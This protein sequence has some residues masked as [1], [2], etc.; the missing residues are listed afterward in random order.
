[1][2]NS[3]TN[4]RQPATSHTWKHRLIQ[5]GI[6]HL[7]GTA[8][9]QDWTFENFTVIF[10]GNS[11]DCSNKTLTKGCSPGSSGQFTNRPMQVCWKARIISMRQL[12][13]GGRI[14]T[15]ACNSLV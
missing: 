9:I 5:P 13:V 3:R 1:M 14:F 8:L 11:A 7:C 10:P 12:L 4:T 15:M 2:V 6:V